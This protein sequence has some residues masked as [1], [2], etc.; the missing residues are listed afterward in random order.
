MS[1]FLGIVSI[2]VVVI[3]AMAFA[4]ASPFSP[5]PVISISE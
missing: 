3:L 4:A 5:G 2:L 1:R